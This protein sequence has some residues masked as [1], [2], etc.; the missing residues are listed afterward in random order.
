MWE[1]DGA[2]MTTSFAIGHSR[3]AFAQPKNEQG[4]NIE[5]DHRT[6]LLALLASTVGAVV[7]GRIDESYIAKVKADTPPL[8]KGD[9]EKMADSDPN[10]HTAIV[11]QA[12]D[13]ATREPLVAVAVLTV[14]EDGLPSWDYELYSDAEGQFVQDA[15]DAIAISDLIV[16]PVTDAQ[17]K[18]QLDE[19]GWVIADSDDIGNEA[20]E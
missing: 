19:L 11:V 2:V 12:T 10:I 5:N 6:Q 20:T 8:T 9:L 4:L 3:S 13:V 7:V 16:I 14:D 15:N 1:R 17:L 18:E